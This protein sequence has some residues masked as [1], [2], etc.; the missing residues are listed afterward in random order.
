V[1]TIIVGFPPDGT[2]RVGTFVVTARGCGA[3]GGA[4]RQVGA[5][6][7]IEAGRAPIGADEANGTNMGAGTNRGLTRKN[8]ARWLCRVSRLRHTSQR[9]T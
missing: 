4:D 8:P 7:I 2:G 9:S 1:A 5:D 6:G 3:D